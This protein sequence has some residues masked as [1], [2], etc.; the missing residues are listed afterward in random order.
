MKYFYKKNRGFTLIELL[1][2]ISIISLLSTIVMG[3]L[4]SARSKARDQYRISS[5]RQISNAL[6]L[7]Y[8]TYNRYPDTQG[9]FNTSCSVA[10]TA[11]WITDNPA[12]PT[13]PLGTGWSD[14]ILN[15]HPHDPRENQ[16][17]CVFP[18]TNDYPAVIGAGL[19][20]YTYNNGQAYYLFA[21]LENNSQYDIDSQQSRWHDVAQT[22][23]GTGGFNYHPQAYTLRSA[24]R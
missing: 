20:Y 11:R 21:R 1:V 15:T 10:P 9:N 19:A 13:T 16:A 2:V 18:L 22:L 5:L 17:N 3:S 12:A 23:L 14:N 6:E 8:S 24:N 4:A 7:F